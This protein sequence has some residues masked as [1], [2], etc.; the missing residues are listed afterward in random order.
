MVGKPYLG[1]TSCWLVIREQWILSR[2]QESKAVGRAHLDLI[3][4]IAA[5]LRFLSEDWSLWVAFVRMT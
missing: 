3:E 4:T 5:L 1:I 2:E